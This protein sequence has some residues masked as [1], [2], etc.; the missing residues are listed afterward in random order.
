L[1]FTPDV[2]EPDSEVFGGFFSVASTDVGESGG[3]GGSA[4]DGPEP[5]PLEEI[6][7]R[8]KPAKI[9]QLPDGV[10]IVANHDFT[11]LPV[12]LS[13]SFA[14]S[15][16][17][18]NPHWLGDVLGTAR[19]KNNAFECP[20]CQLRIVSSE[21]DFIGKVLGSTDSWTLRVDDE[22]EDG[23][24]SDGILLFQPHAISPRS[25]K[26]E[27]RDDDYPVV[28]I[29]KRIPDSRAWVRTNPVFLSCV[30]PLVVKEIFLSI[31]QKERDSHAGQPS[32]VG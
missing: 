24:R 18:R 15:D 8:P 3:S 4:G 6:Q 31:F 32:A 7:K 11:K 25:W 27:V 21:P 10:R 19:L 5:K 17:T 2:T 23:V 26:L 30:L 14:Y 20:S 1:I 16:G 22:K 13:V 12:R 29:D 28:Y 9:E